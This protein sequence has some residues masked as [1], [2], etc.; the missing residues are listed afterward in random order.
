MGTAEVALGTAS[1]GATQIPLL[2]GTALV[3]GIRHFDMAEMHGNQ[4]LIGQFFLLC[5]EVEVLLPSSHRSRSEIFL[6]S[7]IWCT[8]LAP[9]H[10][11]ASLR[12]L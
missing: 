8:N 11:R 6:T 9:T 4:K 5:S 3:P 1:M 12:R 7:K 10:V 2:L